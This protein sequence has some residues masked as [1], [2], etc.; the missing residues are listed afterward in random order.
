M[1]EKKAL[2]V[3]REIN[4]IWKSQANICFQIEISR[5]EEPVVNGLDIWFV[6]Y[7]PGWNGYFETNHEIYVRDN[8]I[9]SEVDYPAKS[10]AARTA[11]HEIG[12]AFGL[13]HR[14]NSNE[15]LMRSKSYGWMLNAW[16]IHKAREG[17]P[18]GARW[19]DD[20]ECPEPVKST[21]RYSGP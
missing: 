21:V 5:N 7:I 19:F 2:L 11:A 12:H 9:L 15:N 4:R 8:P 6:E 17:V 14:Q 13:H 20:P 16:E 10:A 1:T 3:A 18:S